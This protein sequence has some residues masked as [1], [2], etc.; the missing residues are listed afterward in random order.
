MRFEILTKAALILLILLALSATANAQEVLTNAQIVEMSNAGL[1]Q[2]LIILKINSTAGNYDASAGALIAL[3]KV[4]VEDEIIAAMLVV[5]NKTDKQNLNISE[6]TLPKPIVKP[7]AGKTSAQLLREAHTVFFT[8]H[9]LYPSLSDL[10][11]SVLKRPGWSPFNLSI[12]R[13]RNE[14]DLIVEISHEFLTHYN[15]RVVDA[16]TGKVLTASGVTSLGGA[17]AGNVAEKLIKRL[18]EVLA[19]N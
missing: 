13:N 12:T 14:A 18:K 6:Q 5:S 2:E 17:L 3:K 4:G 16:K 1:K 7:D 11:S 10:E 8:K 19:N 9:S 15:F